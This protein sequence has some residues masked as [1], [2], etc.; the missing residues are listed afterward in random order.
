M[1]FRHVER[2]QLRKFFSEIALPPLLI[3]GLDRHATRGI[4]AACSFVRTAALARGGL[5]VTAGIEEKVE[6]KLPAIAHG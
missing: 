3:G 6:G 5:V 1:F 4:A 2:I